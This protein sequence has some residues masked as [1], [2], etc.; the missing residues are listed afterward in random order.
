MTSR[1]VS[2]AE[3]ELT[4]AAVFYEK[5]RA[6]LG[7]EFLEAVEAA[8]DQLLILPGLGRRIE[9]DYRVFVMRRFPYSIVYQE[10]ANE[11]VIVAIAHHSRRPGYW[12]GRI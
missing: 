2:A 11:I 1:F 8:V 5:Q 12:R 3:E 6:I 9:A 4:T 10:S 7:D